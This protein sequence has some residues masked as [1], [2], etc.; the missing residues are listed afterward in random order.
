MDTSYTLQGLIERGE[1]MPSA[2]VA[3]DA[4]RNAYTP[5][6]AAEPLSLTDLSNTQEMEMLLAMRDTA[7]RIARRRAKLRQL[8]ASGLMP[9]WMAQAAV[10]QL[11][12]LKAA[13]RALRRELLTHWRRK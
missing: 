3:G 5:V 7:S 12:E 9:A 10:H 6:S 4:I 8:V 11:Q 13:W 1:T 2:A